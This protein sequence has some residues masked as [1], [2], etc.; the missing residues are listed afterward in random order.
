VQ[1]S[2]NSTFYLIEGNYQ[3]QVERNGYKSSKQPPSPEAED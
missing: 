3:Y 1:S 2:R